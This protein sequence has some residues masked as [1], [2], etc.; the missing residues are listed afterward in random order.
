[1]M[2]LSGAFLCQIF[3][4]VIMPFINTVQNLQ[5]EISRGT[6]SYNKYY[7][8]FFSDFLIGGGVVQVV[9]V[10]TLILI[11][12]FIIGVDTMGRKYDSLSAMPFKREEIILTKWI[13]AALTVVIPVIL[14]FI[15]M[16]FIYAGNKDILKLYMNESMILQ[17]TLINCLVYLFVI[18]FIMLIQSFS[19]K[20]ILGGIVGTIFLMLPMG[21]ATLI[22]EFLKVLALNPDVLSQKQYSSMLSKIEGFALN[23]SLG[24]Y[25]IDISDEYMLSTYQKSVILAIVIPI[26][27]ILLVYSFKKIP[28]ERNGYIVIFKPLEIIFKI[29][30]SACFGLL[31]G[32]IASQM[33]MNHY[34]IYQ[35][36]LNNMTGHLPIANKIISL[37]VLFTLLCGCVVYV[38][39]NRIVEVSKR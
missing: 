16:S 31:G 20:N 7:L 21:L 34:K 28:L 15:V 2:L 17:W 1:M 36:D 30:V 35:F 38:I 12:T 10:G 13:V 11:G 5:E 33:L 26:L 6:Y 4:I 39:T 22:N 29:G 32:V 25:N 19:G 3:L 27:V 9:A 37:A 18:T 14:S 23:A 24:I 8:H